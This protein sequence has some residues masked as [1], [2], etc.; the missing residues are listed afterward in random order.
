MQL[1]R[2]PLRCAPGRGYTRQTGDRGPRWRHWR[3]APGAPR[4]S[5]HPRRREPLITLEPHQPDRSS[6]LV[7]VVVVDVNDLALA[8]G[9]LAGEEL[10]AA[11]PAAKDPVARLKAQGSH[12]VAAHHRLVAVVQEDVVLL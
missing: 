3:C 4:S 7:A 10:R 11:L 12:P 8:V 6:F 5:P 1:Q 2:A 9:H